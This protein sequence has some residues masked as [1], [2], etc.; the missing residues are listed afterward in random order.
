MADKYTIIARSL[1]KEIQ[2]DVI[3]ET[4][5]AQHTCDAK[6]TFSRFAKSHDG[7]FFILDL[8]K[9][10]DFDNIHDDVVIESI[11]N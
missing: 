1:C 11:Y 8:V 3:I 10:Y 6:T 9:T 4:F 5:Y 2:D 7:E